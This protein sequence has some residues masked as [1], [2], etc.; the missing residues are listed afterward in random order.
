MWSSSNSSHSVRSKPWAIAV[1]K[2]PHASSRWTGI[3][4]D[5]RSGIESFGPAVSSATPTAKV[6]KQSRKNVLKWSEL[7]TTSASS[8]ASAMRPATAS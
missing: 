3:A 1:S 8:R 6:G 4:A 2:I 5:G 7:K